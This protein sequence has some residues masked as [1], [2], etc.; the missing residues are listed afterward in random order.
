MARFFAQR[1]L[2]RG[3]IVPDS[4]WVILPFSILCQMSSSARTEVGRGMSSTQRALW[5]RLS[6]KAWDDAV[7]PEECF[8]EE[9]VLKADIANPDTRALLYSMTRKT[10]IAEVAQTQKV[11]WRHKQG[12]ST[13]RVWDLV[14]V[15]SNDGETYQHRLA[16]G[17]TLEQSLE[18]RVGRAQQTVDFQEVRDKQGERHMLKSAQKKLRHHQ[19]LLALVESQTKLSLQLTGSMHDTVLAAQQQ[20]IDRFLAQSEEQRRLTGSQLAAIFD[21][22][23]SRAKEARRS[24]FVTDHGREQFLHSLAGA[25]CPVISCKQRTLFERSAIDQGTTT[26]PT[27]GMGANRCP[28]SSSARDEDEAPKST[29]K[30]CQP[31]ERKVRRLPDSA[32]STTANQRRRV[33]VRGF[34][35]SGASSTASAAAVR[36]C[37]KAVNLMD[38]KVHL[39]T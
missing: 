25:G 17:Q 35:A 11:E 26:A 37:M 13:S 1:K 27:S 10:Y 23:E 28:V 22:G 34:P 21:F 32:A 19:Y 5:V 30:L 31:R 12:D 39:V 6:K 20:Q 14:F 36:S 3:P 9:H 8:D 38:V 15:S 4:S 33:T 16:F 7:L 24:S 2:L 29:A 18:V